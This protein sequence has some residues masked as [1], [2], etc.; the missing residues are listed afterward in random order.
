MVKLK[1]CDI[2][3]TDT[4]VST[5]FHDGATSTNWPPNDDGSFARMAETLGFDDPMAYCYEHDLCHA[6]I[7]E[8]CFDAPSHVLWRAAH[9]LEPDLGNAWEE[10]L[11]YLFQE[12]EYQSHMEDADHPIDSQWR[13]VSRRLMEE[14][15]VH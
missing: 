6:L 2:E 8:V 9:G 14:T 12:W 7:A 15:A 13:E 1:H 4:H 5:T 3:R 10:R 11:V